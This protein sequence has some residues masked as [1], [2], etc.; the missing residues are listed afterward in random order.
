MNGNMTDNDIKGVTRYLY[1]LGFP[2][3]LFA[4]IGTFAM[5]VA[6]YQGDISLRN[7]RFVL[8][9]F[10]VSI[11]ISVWHVPKIYAAGLVQDGN[12]YRQ[13]KLDALVWVVI[14]GVA[15]FYFGHLLL[16]M[17]WQ[18]QWRRLIY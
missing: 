18:E 6:I 8:G 4:A 7:K 9:A 14:F 12:V 3:G 13:F 1:A 16:P 15:A 5:G 17:L 2:V 10:L 11:A